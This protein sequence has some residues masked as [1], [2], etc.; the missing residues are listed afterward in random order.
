MKFFI[1]AY[2]MEQAIFNSI[3]R[4]LRSSIS[5]DHALI[6]IIRDDIIQKKKTCVFYLKNKSKMYV[7]LREVMM[8]AFPYGGYEKILLVHGVRRELQRCIENALLTKVLE[9]TKN[10]T[11]DF[12]SLHINA[13]EKFRHDYCLEMRLPD[14]MADKNFMTTLLAPVIEKIKQNMPKAKPE[15]IEMTQ[16]QYKK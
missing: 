9:F 10:F 15:Y 3:E 1:N 16:L 2:R 7:T 11:E 8:E 5:K 14:D 4:T 12:L 13:F 6:N